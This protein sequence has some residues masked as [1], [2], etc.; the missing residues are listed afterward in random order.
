LFQPR[1]LLW[2]PAAVLPAI[3]LAGIIGSATLGSEQKLVQGR[4]YRTVDGKVDE[5]TY[6]GFRRYNAACNH[7]HGPDGMGSTFAPSLVD[8]LPD[9]D[10]FRRIVL[11]GLVNGT[12]GMRGF[13]GDPN[14]APYVD[15]I[16]AYLQARTEGA[17][18]RGRPMK[19]DQ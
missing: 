8:G 15:D 11:E 16:Y 7:C 1:K 2:F 14:I 6:N 18:G 10:A 12:S 4:F 19:L 9:V 3:A 13:A 17:L 5:R